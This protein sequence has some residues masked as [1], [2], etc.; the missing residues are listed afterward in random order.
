MKILAFESSAKAASVVFWEDGKLLAQSY[1]NIGLTHS[2][3]LL[4]M[5]EAMLENSEIN[6][7]DAD[8]LAVA[9][10][11]GSFTGIRIGISTVKGLCWASG[12]PCAG[13]ST[14]LSM[15]YNVY[16]TDKTICAVMDA[17]GGQ[18]YNGL[19]KNSDG[20]VLRLC[21][22]RAITIKTLGEEIKSSGESYIIVGDGAEICYNTFL[23]SGIMNMYLAPANFRYQN[24]YGVACAAADQY[25]KETAADG[26]ALS[27]RYLRLPQAERERLEKARG[28]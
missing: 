24:A 9:N 17:R 18:V 3:T 14:L 7:F 23:E 19:F 8:L 10:G 6:L 16:P 12:K 26:A 21:E 13:V 28:F 1:Q 20:L 5:A 11:P 2:Y 22:D 15:A 4:P 25:R 27:A